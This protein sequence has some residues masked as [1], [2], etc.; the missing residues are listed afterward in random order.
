MIALVVVM[1][2]E[3]FDLTFEVT[4][5][6]VAFHQHAVLKR[7]VPPLF[8]AFNLALGLR[9]EGCTAYMIHAVLAEIVDQLFNDVARPIVR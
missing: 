5:Q 4:G 8:L 9:M 1:L 3:G 2:C 6:E 7:L